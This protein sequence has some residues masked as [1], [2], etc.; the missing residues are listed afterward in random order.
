MLPLQIKR[1]VTSEVDPKQLLRAHVEQ[2]PIEKQLEF[3]ET[4]LELLGNRKYTPKV[5]PA[6]NAQLMN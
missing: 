4:A 6:A 1:R 5:A 3:V 2:M